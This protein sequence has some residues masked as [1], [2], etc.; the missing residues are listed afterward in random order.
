MGWSRIST[1]CVRCD[2]FIKYPCIT[3]EQLAADYLS[4]RVAMSNQLL[5]LMCESWNFYPNFLQFYDRDKFVTFTSDEIL[6]CVN[7]GSIYGP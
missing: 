5:A 2:E 4:L 7:K 3:G 6:F 1:L